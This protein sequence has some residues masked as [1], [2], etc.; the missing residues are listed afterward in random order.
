M[1]LEG[2][3][4]SAFWIVAALPL[5]GACSGALTSDL[6]GP[7]EKL[8][9]V[10][11]DGSRMVHD[12]GRPSSSD[13]GPKDATVR[14]EAASGNAIPKMDAA[15]ELRD[16]SADDAAVDVTADDAPVDMPQGVPDAATCLLP[17]GPGQRC[18]TLLGALSSGQC[19]PAFCQFCCQ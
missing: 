7:P 6:D 19:Y 8:A 13:E 12:A 11:G 17:C 5:A 15:D 1:R 10:Q 4:S 9:V 3:R 16:E 14:L 2:R 18:C